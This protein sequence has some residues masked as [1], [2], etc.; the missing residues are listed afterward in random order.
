M[1]SRFSKRSFKEIS[2]NS[3]TIRSRDFIEIAC[4]KSEH[5]SFLVSV[6]QIL[7]RYYH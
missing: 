7:I 1:Q 4:L 3:S 6:W 2:L 5:G